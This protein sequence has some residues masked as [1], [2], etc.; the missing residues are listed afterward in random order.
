[1]KN[2]MKKSLLFAFAFILFLTSYGQYSNATLNG[3]WLMQTDNDVYIIFDGNGYITEFGVFNGVTGSNVGTYS[4]ES[5]GAIEG[6]F[7]IWSMP[8][9]GQLTSVN[10]GSLDISGEGTSP[11]NRVMSPGAL[12]ELLTGTM[13]NDLDNV[14]KSVEFTIN[15]NGQIVSS[16]GDLNVINGRI[17]TE[18]GIIA[19]HISTD[20]N[21][22][23]S[24][25]IISG[26]YSD[27]TI[28]GNIELDCTDGGGPVSLVRSGNATIDIN[29][30]SEKNSIKVYPNPFNNQIFIS[31]SENKVIDIKDK[32]E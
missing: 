16:T 21:G 27:N 28:S 9:T 26:T 12:T 4:V 31:N 3:A 22:C 30:V 23:W 19:G 7:T 1:M 29:F 11:L 2:L 17:Y 14:T 8:F 5:N 15:E 32:R 10:A 6:N 20:D 18:N 13:T 24:E 25:M